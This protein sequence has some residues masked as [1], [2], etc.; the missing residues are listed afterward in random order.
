ML[1][2]AP[3]HRRTTYP[4]KKN[5]AFT[6]IEL[7]VVIAII[8]I[9]AAILFPVFAQAKL[10]AKKT[11]A[12]SNAKQL[13]LANLIYMNDY[14]D[15]LVK[16]WFGFPSNCWA[17][18]PYPNIFY[19]WRYAEQ[20]YVKS[21]GLLQDPTNQYQTTA[22]WEESWTDGTLA[23]MVR[24]P[25]N[26]AVNN[27][28]IGF[29]NGECGG[30]GTPVGLGTLDQV[31]NPADVIIMLPN[32]SQWND[33]KL[34]FLS[35]LPKYGGP[36]AGGWNLQ[37]YDNNNNDTG[38]LC[39]PANDGPIQ[40]IGNQVSWVWCDGHAKT[41]P[42]LATLDLGDPNNDHWGATQT[43]YLLPSSQQP[44]NL[45]IR[46]DINANAYVEYQTGQQ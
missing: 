17:A 37:T 2:F 46:Q 22:D 21:K 3:V 35:P 6:L 36:C 43:G 5:K 20:P 30:I 45:A 9:L 42:P 15:N 41:M 7:L 39:P 4:V 28:V 8:A 19:N 26:Y 12:L 18:P 34:T 33:L 27:T 10:A 23:D 38:S 44:V 40:A 16:E 29:A 32:R 14:D 25:Q 24:L 1:S 13:G 31:P 11:V